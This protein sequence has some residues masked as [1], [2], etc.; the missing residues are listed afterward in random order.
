M[1]ASSAMEEHQG[2]SER[3]L[4]HQEPK[5][6]RLASPF[7]YC[8]EGNQDISPQS[9]P[10]TSV[11]QFFFWLLVFRLIYLHL[12]LCWIFVAARGLFP[13]AVSMAALHWGHSLLTAVVYPV[14]EHGL[15][16][17]GSRAQA[18]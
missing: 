6:P 9:L 11:H 10:H 16:L 17:T 3:S 5:K 18:Q 4:W 2:S 14:S 1:L 7:P 12:R 8:S 13:I 15:G